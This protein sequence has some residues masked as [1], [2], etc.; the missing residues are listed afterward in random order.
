MA[1]HLL[2]GDIFN[3]W[4]GRKYYPLGYRFCLEDAQP[5]DKSYIERILKDIRGQL[6]LG[7]T[8]ALPAYKG[9]TCVNYLEAV[10]NILG[11]CYEVYLYE[12]DVTDSQDN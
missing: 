5:F 6:N 9:K 7:D 11:L 10:Q 1:I 12:C 4:I 8:I 3:S 2:T